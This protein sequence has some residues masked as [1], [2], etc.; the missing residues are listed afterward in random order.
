MEDFMAIKTNFVSLVG[1]VGKHKEIKAFENGGMLCTIGLGVKTG[2]NWNNMFIDFFNTQNK[3]LAE[4]AGEQLE[5]GM[6][7]NILGRLRV[8]KFTPESMK[9]QKD[10]N[11]NEKTV[12]QLKVVAFDF[13]PVRYNEESE[14]FELIE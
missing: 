14:Q 4:L 11:G 7:I 6:Y 12:S 5:E 3:N 13:K 10:E 2:E 8:N 9:G 1:R